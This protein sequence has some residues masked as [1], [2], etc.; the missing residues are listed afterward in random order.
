M[1]F[2]GLRKIGQSPGM[3]SKS[4]ETSFLL[5]KRFRYSI[6][7]SS[8][9][10]FSIVAIFLDCSRKF[11]I[12]EFSTSSRFIGSLKKMMSAQVEGLI[13]IETVCVV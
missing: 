11:P 9:I 4:T 13:V 7:C 8:T 10:I 3:V 6:D 12:R 5:K 2:D 1:D